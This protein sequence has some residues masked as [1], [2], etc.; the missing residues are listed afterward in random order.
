MR[1]L[2]RLNLRELEEPRNPSMEVDL[3]LLGIKGS[4]L[5][6][7]GG[8]VGCLSWEVFYL[9]PNGRR[10]LGEIQNS[11][12]GS[13][14]LFD[15]GFSPVPVAFMTRPWTGSRKWMDEWMFGTNCRDIFPYCNKCTKNDQ[16]DHVSQN[17]LLFFLTSIYSLV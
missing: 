13:L 17:K 9:C 6:L 10:C 4:H 12:V 15:L 1:F 16:S 5:R 11:L 8:G 3:L 14:I 2:Y 7:S